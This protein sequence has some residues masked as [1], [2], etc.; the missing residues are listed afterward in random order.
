MWLET[1]QQSNFTCPL[2]GAKW[3]ACPENSKSQFLGC[4][5]ASSDPCELGCYDGNL[6][7]ATF[8]TTLYGKIPDALCQ[9]G[10][11]KF[12]TCVTSRFWGCCTVN[13]CDTGCPNLNVEAA[14]LPGGGL[15]AI[16]LTSAAA[17]STSTTSSGTTSQTSTSSSSATSVP[18]PTSAAHKSQNVGAIAGGAAGGVALLAIIIGW[19]LYH[20]LYARKSRKLKNDEMNRQ[21]T[22]PPANAVMT[23]MPKDSSFH[24]RP[25]KQCYFFCLHIF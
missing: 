11:K 15:N 12:Y 6:S 18:V 24:G 17:S 8:D 19:L 13:P 9:S 25:G 5:S 23:E 2:E 7:N 4:C 1:R 3:Y 14:K 22:L 20:Y 16:Y 21:N 10:D